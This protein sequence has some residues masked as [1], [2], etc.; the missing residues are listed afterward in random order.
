MTTV[1]Q[2]FQRSAPD[3]GLVGIGGWLV[4]P[5]IGL[6]L[7]FIGTLVAFVGYFA[8]LGHLDELGVAYAVSFFLDVALFALLCYA[9]AQFFRKRREAPN[10]MC[11]LMGLTTAAKGILY[12]VALGAEAEELA[13]ESVRQFFVG[14][15]SAAIWIPYFRVSKRVKATFVK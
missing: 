8:L 2:E 4:L 10:A 13:S 5:A 6:V 7:R 9:M 15:V 3:S 1:E 14:G 11:G 12:L